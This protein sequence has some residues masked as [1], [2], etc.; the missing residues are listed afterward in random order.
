[1]SV[2]DEHGAPLNDLMVVNDHELLVENIAATQEL[3]KT[4]QQLRSAS[5]PRREEPDSGVIDHVGGT[6]WQNWL[7]CWPWVRLFRMP[8]RGIFNLGPACS[9]IIIGFF[10]PPIWFG[11]IWYMCSPRRDH[12]LSGFLCLLLFSITLSLN[13]GFKIFYVLPVMRFWD[14]Y[15]Q[16]VAV[17]IILVGWYSVALLVTTAAF[18]FARCRSNKRQSSAILP[19]DA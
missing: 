1:V 14:Y 10:Y 19:T 7:F 2:L 5:P 18:L 15:S 9:Y 13:C 3:G 8:E 6:R 16:A 12:H 4:V 11:G 17:Y